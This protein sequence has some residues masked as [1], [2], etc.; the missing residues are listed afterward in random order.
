LLGRLLF[1][2]ALNVVV[3]EPAGTVTVDVGTASSALLLESET[4]VPP[5]G[6]AWL[7]VTV[8]VVVAADA[9]FVG[10]QDNEDK[11]TTGAVKLIVQVLDTPLSV[12]VRVAL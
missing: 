7:R 1:A 2:V 3:A 5:V 6:A 9:R 8:H 4:T 10:V 12:A 11:T